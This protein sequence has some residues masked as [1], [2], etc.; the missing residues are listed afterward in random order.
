MPYLF[1]LFFHCSL[2]SNGS[3]YLTLLFTA[4][5]FQKV[6]QT[7]LSFIFHIYKQL[8]IK[9]PQ[10]VTI[11]FQCLLSLMQTKLYK[12]DV[13]TLYTGHCYTAVISCLQTGICEDLVQIQSCCRIY[14]SY[15]RPYSRSYRTYTGALKPSSLPFP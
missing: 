12:R 13:K 4:F 10:T 14:W 3:L 6:I 7:N 1:K 9:V 2:F 11:Y 8:T 15:M 5:L